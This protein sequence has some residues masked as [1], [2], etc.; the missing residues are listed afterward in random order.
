MRLLKYSTELVM[1]LLASRFLM[2][3]NMYNVI[4]VVIALLSAQTPGH[5]LRTSLN[6]K[7][8]AVCSTC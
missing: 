3:M 8:H 7:I 5:P 6:F 1:A 2:D 4:H